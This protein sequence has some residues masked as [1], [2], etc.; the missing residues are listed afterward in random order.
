MFHNSVQS[1]WIFSGFLPALPHLLWLSAETVQLA[2]V[3]RYSSL[4]SYIQL[5]SRCTGAPLLRSQRVTLMPCVAYE[6]GMF[7]L[8][9]VRTYIFLSLFASSLCHFKAE[10]KPSKPFRKLLLHVDQEEITTDKLLAV[11][12]RQQSNICSA[13][14]VIA[15]QK[16]WSGRDGVLVL[17]DLS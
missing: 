17:A 14:R 9:W 3:A 6:P 16:K 12:I 5:P 8:R 7:C 15:E 13:L 4:R 11:A 1:L 10:L 2:I